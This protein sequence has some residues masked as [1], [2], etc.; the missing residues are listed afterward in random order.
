MVKEKLKIYLDT[1][2]ISA[3]FDERLLERQGYTKSSWKILKN[4]D[5]YISQLV[6]KEINNHPD[7]IKRNKMLQLVKNFKILSIE[8]KEI[9]E[10]A[11]EYVK[12]KIIPEKYWEDALHLACASVNELNILTSWNYAHLLKLNTKTRVNAINILLGYKPIELV[13]PPML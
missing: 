4:Y 9:K 5:I 12:K 2:V 1:S 11:Q 8:T 7:T 3:Y 13:E 6:L 10:L